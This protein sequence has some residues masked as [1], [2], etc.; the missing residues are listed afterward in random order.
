M[1]KAIA[2]FL[3]SSTLLITG[4]ATDANKNITTD[5][6]VEN[7]SLTLNFEF[8]ERTGTYTGHLVDGLPDGVG[9]FASTNDNGLDW[10]YIGNWKSGHFDGQGTSFFSDDR[11][12]VSTYK[13]DYANGTGVALYSDGS[14][15]HGEITNGQLTGNGTYFSLSGNYSGIFSNGSLNGQGTA[16]YSGNIVEGT[17]KDGRL[18]GDGTIN[19]LSGEKVIGKFTDDASGLNGSGILYSTDGSSKECEFVNGE[20]KFKDS[21]ESI[22]SSESDNGTEEPNTETSTDDNDSHTGIEKPE[23]KGR[24]FSDSGRNEPKYENVIGYAVVGS[25]EELSIQ[26]SEYFSDTPWKVPVYSKDKQFYSENGNIEHKT[27]VLVKSQQLE[28]EGYGAYS[29]YLLVERLDTNEELYLNVDNFIT[30]AYWTNTSIENAVS[31]GYCIA[32]YNQVSDYYPADKGNRKVEIVDGAKVLVIGKTGLFG[33]GPDRN[34]NSIEAI[35]YNG[36]EGISAF[37]NPQ[38]LSI[39]Y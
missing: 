32:E 23:L 38:D 31:V 20:I 37:F 10:T 16:Y 22:P 7:M 12:N 18:N 14:V 2:S 33:G 6:Y 26:S 34:T 13:N 39:I 17:F 8:G 1:R 3:L 30:K 4:C 29:G 11:I 15:Y 36:H 24:G 5:T 19:Y 9:E 27:K 35:V 21:I 25:G 28:H